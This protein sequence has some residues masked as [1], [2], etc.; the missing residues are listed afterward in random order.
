M[1]KTNAIKLAIERGEPVE[2]PKVIDFFDKY[3]HDI[4]F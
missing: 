4:T 2:V 3:Y 1:K